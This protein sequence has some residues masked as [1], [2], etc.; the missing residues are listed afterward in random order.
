MMYN[1]IF[2]ICSNGMQDL[3]RLAQVYFPAQVILLGSSVLY[4]ANKQN[5]ILKTAPILFYLSYILYKIPSNWSDYFFKEACV[6]YKTIFDFN[7]I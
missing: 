6:P 4:F 5:I 7:L 3:N 2:M 1:A